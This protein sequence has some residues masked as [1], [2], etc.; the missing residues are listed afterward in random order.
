MTYSLAAPSRPAHPARAALT[1]A[2]LALLALG[3]GLA[4]SPAFG[5]ALTLSDPAPARLLVAVAAGAVAP[6]LVVGIARHC[7]LAVTAAAAAAL[8]TTVLAVALAARPGR[9][10]A[11]GPYRLLTSALPSDATGPVTAAVGFLTGFAALAS[12]LLAAYSR[13]RAFAVV[14]P[15]V[16]LVAGLA[17]DA[18]VASP[19][20]WYAAAVLVPLGFALVL[21]RDPVRV[22]GER[23]GSRAS[24]RTSA[25]TAARTAGVAR[26]TA[27]LA[28]AVAVLAAGSALAA[29]AA[30][31]LPAVRTRP[32]DA[33]ALVDAPLQPRSAVN[34]IVRYPAWARGLEPLRLTGT[35]SRP[36][37]RLVLTTLPEFTGAGWTADSRF[38]RAGSTL[39][40]AGGAGG[41]TVRVDIRTRT[42]G[43]LAWLPRPDRPA[44]LS[45]A[46]GQ[47]SDLGVDEQTGDLVVPG[48]V[49]FP[50]R[51]SVTGSEPVT[52]A[53]VG[54]GDRAVRRTGPVSTGDAPVPDVVRRF[55]QGTRDLGDADKL[56]AVANLLRLDD[57]YV[58]DSDDPRSGNGWFQIV[59][60]LGAPGRHIGTSEQYASTFAVLARVLGFQSRVVVGFVPRYADNGRDFTITGRDVRAWAQVRFARA[61]WVTY[62]ATPTR[63][64]GD[65]DTR[66]ER[67]D[68]APR[69]GSSP[70]PSSNAP[71]TPPTSTSPPPRADDT[72]TRGS[73]PGPLLLV[74]A[75]AAVIVL[76]LAAPPGVKAGRRRRRRGAAVPA[77]AVVGAWRETA[78]RLAELGRPPQRGRLTSE[79]A[80]SAPEAA[81]DEV[82]AL[83]RLLD[84]AGYAPEAAG[85][86]DAAAA[87]RHADAARDRIHG[88]L[89]PVRRVLAAL[90]PRPLW[91][92]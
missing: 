11:A 46:A 48:G 41:P 58:D 90:D 16:P 15:F 89:S 32:A 42:A 1:Q 23:A 26:R 43:D 45:L 30:P 62:D 76:L 80:A 8:V 40:A 51:Y 5:G 37:S 3:C 67:P 55:V 70:T 22:G 64:A 29:T 84:R 50:G 31:D 53:D 33:R 77:H 78:D 82:R 17:L 88:Q 86:D 72:D 7:G 56:A 21:V 27:A 2:V 61:G 10:V 14:P 73:G 13:R 25:R 75:L 57:W 20:S 60:L 35:A 4:A 87:W 79:V 49:S 59:K 19:P 24:A 38:R 47:P 92:R 12:C 83:G 69:G 39:R 52:G 81:R 71:S 68:P 91:R 6:A 9:D 28:G 85:A 44:G 74:A 34:P 18:S 63:R 36:V 65:T 54:R 66:R